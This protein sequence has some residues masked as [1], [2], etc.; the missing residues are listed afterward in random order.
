MAIS[1]GGVS[2]EELGLPQ[3]VVVVAFTSS[4][5]LVL[6]CI[7]VLA[8]SITWTYVRQLRVRLEQVE[9]RDKLRDEHVDELCDKLQNLVKHGA[10]KVDHKKV[11]QIEGQKKVTVSLG[12]IVPDAG[13]VVKFG[14]KAL[15]WALGGKD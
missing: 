3:N 2:E 8:F 9:H 4:S 5:T 11:E 14:F 10:I 15:K 12:T 1:E 6:G 13:T 7:L